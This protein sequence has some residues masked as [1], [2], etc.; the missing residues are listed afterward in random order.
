MNAKYIESLQDAIQHTHG[1]D[2][3][4]VGTVPVLEVFQGKIAWQGDVEVF[5][6]IDHPKARQGYA[7]GFQDDSGKWQ[8]VAVLKVSPVDSP[9]KAVQAYILTAHQGKARP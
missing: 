4:H 6:L 8:Y 5:D 3:R 1:C 7:W 2:S 9:R